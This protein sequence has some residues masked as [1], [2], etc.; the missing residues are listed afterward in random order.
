MM[1]KSSPNKWLLFFLICSFIHLRRLS[2]HYNH[3][4]Q[5]CYLKIGNVKRSKQ[6][7]KVISKV[8][9]VVDPVPN[10]FFWKFTTHVFLKSKQLPC[11]ASPFIFFRRWMKV[12]NTNENTLL[13][14][15]KTLELLQI[16]K[17]FFFSNLSN[18]EDLPNFFY[19]DICQL[20]HWVIFRDHQ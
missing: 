18:E 19:V 7:G 17:S 6:Y 1:V 8:H 3:Q 16:P 20:I 5:H 9:W 12:P 2:F 10:L 11:K 4:K 15:C 13:G 14:R